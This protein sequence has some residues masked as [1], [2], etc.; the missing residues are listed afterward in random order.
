MKNLTTRTP[1][2]SPLHNLTS[3]LSSTSNLNSGQVSGKL[4]FNSSC[5]RN[6]SEKYNV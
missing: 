3:S 2:N 1:S 6:F 5:T 4:N